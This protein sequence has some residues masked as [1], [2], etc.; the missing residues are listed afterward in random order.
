MNNTERGP[1][2]I[3]WGEEIP[4]DFQGEA[5]QRPV[6]HFKE[7][8]Q[9]AQELAERLEQLMG[10]FTSEPYKRDET[11]YNY[12]VTQC[13][14]LLARRFVIEGPEGLYEGSGSSMSRQK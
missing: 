9:I 5:S 2:N 11:R 4:P 14:S 13:L 3:A 7:A 10:Q 8:E 1:S 6:L 12:L